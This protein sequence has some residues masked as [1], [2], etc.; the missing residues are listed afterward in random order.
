MI[1]VNTDVTDETQT[2]Y[3][4]SDADVLPLSS[5]EVEKIDKI[6]TYQQVTRISQ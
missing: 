2:H 1:F 6:K 3:D 5:S 4:S